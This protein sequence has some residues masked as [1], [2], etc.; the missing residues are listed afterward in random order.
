MAKNE[1]GHKSSFALELTVLKHEN[2]EPRQQV[3]YQL[4]TTVSG[5]INKN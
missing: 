4:K 3:S 1:V 2:K 5:N